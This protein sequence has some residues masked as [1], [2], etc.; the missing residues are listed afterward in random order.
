MKKFIALIASIGISFMAFAQGGSRPLTVREV[1]GD[2]IAKRVDELIV[3]NGSLTKESERKVTLTIGAGGATAWDDIGNPD[4]N[5][6]I[7]FAAYTI[8]L[9]VA[10]FQIGDGGGVNYVGFDGTPTMTFNGTADINLPDDS[11]DDADLN[12][13][14]GATQISASDMLDEDIGDITISS[15]VY[16]VDAGAIHDLTINV[17]EENTSAIV[18]GQAAYV[19]GSVG[20]GQTLVGLID[21]TDSAKIRALGL[22]AEAIAQNATGTVRFR[23]EVS[24]VDTLGTNAV[25]PN[26]ETWVAGDILY[27]TNTGSSGGLTNVKPTSGRII[28][29]G[30]SLV[31]SHNNHTILVQP[32][33]NPTC[34]AAASG[35]DIC[36]RMGDNDGAKKVCFRDYANNDVACVDSNGVY[37]C[38]GLTIGSAV[39]IEAELEMLDGI[40]AGTAAASKALVL[41]ASKDIATINS[42][43]AITLIGAL[44]GN[45]TTCT[46][47]SAGDSA[48]AFFDSGTIEHEYGGVEANVSAYSGLIGVNSGSTSEVNTEAELE[49]HLGGLDVVCVTVDDIT[50]ANLASIIDGETG[51]GD[52]VFSTSP[53]FVTSIIMGA[54]TLSEAELEILDGATLG[55]ADI[56]IIDG[57]ADSGSLTAIELLYVDGVTE[58]IQTQIDTKGAHAG[59]VWTG[60]HDF[61]GTTSIEIFNAADVSG[62][63]TEGMISWDN[64][65]DKLYMG[66][67]TSVKEI[68]ATYREYILYP[69]SAIL[70]D[71]NPPAITIIESTGTGTPRFRV[72]DFDATSDE[73]IYFPLILP[74]DYK[75]S[76]SLIVEIYWFADDTGADEDAIWA[77]Q[78]S[79]TTPADADSV[80][81][82]ACDSDVATES[83]DVDTNEANR[84]L[85][86]II[87][88]TYATYM[89]AATAGDSI[90]LRFF[91]DADDSVGDADNDSLT[92]DARLHRIVVKIP[93]G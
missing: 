26:G 17:K 24:G 81:E 44:T 74:S 60:V 39:I 47:A 8:E 3:S 59:Q 52:P 66:D 80:I 19:S 16:T 33:E 46:T 20:A 53:T 2:P 86:T 43:T 61:G 37:T 23:G 92:S 34:L 11:V 72:A 83:G 30:Y 77:I 73:I 78:V 88:L 45:A 67:G 51:T 38:T 25:N 93:R 28:R 48:T 15:G 63:T 85:K 6:E 68:G 64:D 31:G 42:L 14:T 70:D 5:D 36:I 22:A 13:G 56:N 4:A 10:D 69:S 50:S 7:D 89:D 71:N 79:A 57:I 91:R 32:H 75:A 29:A 12:L 62:N 76:S 90:E 18:K 82:Q 41:D 21:N 40:T 84:L 27:C 1:D 54:A 65:D 58:A 35:E 55:T 87:T 9:N 49:T